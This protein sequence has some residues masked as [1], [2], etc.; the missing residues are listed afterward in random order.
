[1]QERDIEL[2]VACFFPFD[3][4]K[5]QEI[6]AINK[7]IKKSEAWKNVAFESKKYIA[8]FEF[9]IPSLINILPNGRKQ[10]IQKVPNTIINVFVDILLSQIIK[11]NNNPITAVMWKPMARTIKI[12][13]L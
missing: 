1:M 3:R 5:M 4:I 9:K 11:Y 6:N 2:I 7:H 13:D 10:Q 12:I 8:Y